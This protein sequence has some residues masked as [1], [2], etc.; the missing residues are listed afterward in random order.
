MFFLFTRKLYLNT[1]NESFVQFHSLSSY[2]PVSEKKD[3]S[4]SDRS[5]PNERSTQP[6]EEG[7]ISTSFPGVSSTRPYGARESSLSLSLRRDGEE[8]PRGT[9][10]DAFFQSGQ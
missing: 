4:P 1:V 10:L 3:P 5:N 9:R 2:R 6:G 7:C 8:K